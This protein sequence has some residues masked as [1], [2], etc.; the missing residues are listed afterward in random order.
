MINTI[1]DFIEF[2]R[3][4]NKRRICCKRF[5]ITQALIKYFTDMQISKGT[6]ELPPYIS[7]VNEVSKLKTDRQ[8][9]KMYRKLEVAGMV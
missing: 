4:K 2:H 7:A 5:M 6:V 1:K 9:N 8:I 3:M